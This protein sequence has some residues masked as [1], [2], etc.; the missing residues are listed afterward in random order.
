MLMSIFSN[1]CRGVSMLYLKEKGSVQSGGGP[2]FGERSIALL[3]LVRK[4][5]D[6]DKGGNLMGGKHEFSAL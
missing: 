3:R 1:T 4:E 2:A 5:R 6:G